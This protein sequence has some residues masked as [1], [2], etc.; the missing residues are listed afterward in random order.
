MRMDISAGFL[1]TRTDAVHH[2]E[3]GFIAVVLVSQVDH[4]FGLVL[5]ALEGAAFDKARIVKRC[6]LPQKDLHVCH[7]RLFFELM[8][9]TL[10]HFTRLFDGSVGCG[11][12]VDSES[13][14]TLAGKHLCKYQLG[15]DHHHRP[16]QCGQHQPY[17]DPAVSAAFKD[18][19]EKWFKFDHRSS[20]LGVS[21]PSSSSFSLLPSSAS[22]AWWARTSFL[23]FLK[24]RNFRAKNGAKT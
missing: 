14:G 15:R 6:P 12:D 9:H 5:E 3:R 13:V 21:V 4:H 18:I 24:L 16:H 19:V 8:H 2:F 20:P 10:G 17:D 23:I 22:C 1:D 11:V 7:F